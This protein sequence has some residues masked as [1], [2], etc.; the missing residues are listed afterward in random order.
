MKEHYEIDKKLGYV[1]LPYLLNLYVYMR[2][3]LFNGGSRWSWSRIMCWFGRHNWELRLRSFSAKSVKFHEHKETK[4]GYEI[5]FNLQCEDC[6]ISKK[7]Y[8]EYR[9]FDEHRIKS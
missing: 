7:Y 3:G 9:G 6:G 1:K 8:G 4:D 5:G 2:Q